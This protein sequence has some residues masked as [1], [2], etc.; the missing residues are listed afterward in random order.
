ME[1]IRD[2]EKVEPGDLMYCEGSLLVVSALDTENKIFYLKLDDGRTFKK[3]IEDTKV[4]RF[5][6]EI[7]ILKNNTST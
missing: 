3:I 5:Y 7:K 4:L 1:I 6:R 2:I